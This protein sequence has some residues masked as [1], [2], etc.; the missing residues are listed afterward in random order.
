MRA[1][2]FGRLTFMA[3]GGGRRYVNVRVACMSNDSEQIA[4]LAHELRHAVEIADASYV[5]DVA[6]LR[7]LYERIGFASHGVAGGAGYKSHAAIDSARCVWAEL[8]RTAE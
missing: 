5:V 7:A 4:A 8:G 1:R 6:S 3:A 2:L